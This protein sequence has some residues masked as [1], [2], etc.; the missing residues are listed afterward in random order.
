MVNRDQGWVV[1]CSFEH[2]RSTVK[3]ERGDWTGS[4]LVVKLMETGFSFWEQF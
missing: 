4:L 3:W 1:G 2:A